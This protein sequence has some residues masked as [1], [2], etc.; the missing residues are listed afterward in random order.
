MRI[1]IA[2]ALLALAAALLWAGLAS[3][4]G[5]LTLEGRTASSLTVSWNWGGQAVSVWELAWRARVDDDAAAWRSARKAA[6]QR[7]H[8]I[9]GLEAGGR[10]IVRVRALDA[11]DRPFASLRGAF[12]TSSA[13]TAGQSLDPRLRRGLAERLTLELES[14]RELCTAGT[15]TEVSWQIAGGAP[16]YSL[17]VE[18]FPVNTEADNMRINCGALSEAEAADEDAALAAKRVT[19]VVTDA[20]GVRREAALDVARAA[21]AAPPQRSLIYPDTHTLRF[22]WPLSPDEP[23]DGP[24][25]LYLGRWRRTGTSEWTA[26]RLYRPFDGLSVPYGFITD[27]A[28]STSYEAQFAAMRHELEAETPHVLRWSPVFRGSTIGAPSGVTAFATHDTVTVTWDSHP[29]ATMYDV[30]IWQVGDEEPRIYRTELFDAATEGP[31]EAAPQHSVV[32]RRLPPGRDYQVRVEFAG[33][34]PNRAPPFTTVPIQT[35]P[36][37]VAWT[38]PPKG[39]Q[40]LRAAATYDSITVYWD[41]PSPEPNA[42][43]D[44]MLIHPEYSI[45]RRESTYRGAASFTFSGLEPGVPYRIIVTHTTDDV[46]AEIALSTPSLPDGAA[47]S[48]HEWPF[49]TPNFMWPYILRSHL[50]M[51]TDMWEWAG[52]K[53]HGGLDFGGFPDAASHDDIVASAP[54]LARAFDLRIGVCKNADLPTLRDK[55]CAAVVYC[56]DESR[57]F[58]EQFHVSN[59]STKHAWGGE[60][61]ASD[62]GY[63]ATED[64]GIVVLVFHEAVG[65]RRFVTKYGH[66]RP[67]YV[68]PK[69]TIEQGHS[70]TRPEPVRVAAGEKL[71]REGNTGYSKG[72]HLHFEVRVFDGSKDEVSR[73]WFT[74]G[75]RFV[76][77]CTGTR[78]AKKEIRT[79]VTAS[80]ID[81]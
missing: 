65:G 35:K 79:K 24:P 44:L 47:P 59:S 10:Y 9:E 71:G 7:R 54:G 11:N 73:N 27:L 50:Y 29:T 75:G 72:A 8:T 13:A 37:P 66:L 39:P 56:P 53:F 42:A 33:I 70:A 80:G 69:L 6:A 40:N 52:R 62:C 21:P 38:A 3:A 67:D 2:A 36:A 41:H 55:F 64:S 26:S 28:Q 78:V 81:R 23:T 12:A 22:S 31:T 63:L 57:P 1:S 30:A 77:G 14:S 48:S 74:S 46:S 43:Y 32:F 4:D 15:L 16:P 58:A 45:P 20:R 34:D 51:T 61:F 5:P 18:G 17:Q 76:F 68:S 60:V 25:L 49:P 19:A